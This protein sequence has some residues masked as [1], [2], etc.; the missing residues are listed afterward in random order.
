MDWHLYV[1]LGVLALGAI[2]LVSY[3]LRPSKGAA[4]GVVRGV[5][6]IFNYR[7]IVK[8]FD[9]RAREIYDEDRYNEHVSNG[10]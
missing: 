2:G 10:N 1:G 8:P 5:Y 7:P 9:K 6:G 4:S 3:T